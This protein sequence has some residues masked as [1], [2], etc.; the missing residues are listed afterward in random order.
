MRIQYARVRLAISGAM[1]ERGIGC[2]VEPTTIELL[3][4]STG[5]YAVVESGRIPVSKHQIHSV[6]GERT[7]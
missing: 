5:S 4:C 6:C 3:Q 1:F 2:T 7:G